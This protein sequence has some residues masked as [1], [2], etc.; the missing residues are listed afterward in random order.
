MTGVARRHT[1][2]GC[3]CGPTLLLLGSHPS[4]VQASECHKRV[5][6][7]QPVPTCDL[8]AGLGVLPALASGDD[9]LNH[10]SVILCRHIV[11]QGVKWA[12]LLYAKQPLMQVWKACERAAGRAVCSSVAYPRAA[13]RTTCKGTR[14]ARAVC[15]Q[16]IHRQT[17]HCQSARPPG[18]PFMPY[19]RKLNAT[20]PRG[21]WMGSAPGLTAHAQGG[22]CTRAL[23]PGA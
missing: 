6:D 8:I 13:N 11:W 1:R 3:Q 14:S 7:C 4:V 15:W 5:T 10:P 22:R 12:A 23:P 21:G 2:R 19:C 9:L 17:R 16:P 20:T 18:A